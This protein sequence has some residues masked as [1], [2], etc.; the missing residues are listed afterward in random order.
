MIISIANSIIHVLFHKT[1]LINPPPLSPYTL[2]CHL[3]T[4]FIS[5]NQER[6]IGK[7]LLELFTKRIE[8]FIHACFLYDL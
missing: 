8:K 2:I 5:E 7:N 6:A 1:S 4:T 3:H